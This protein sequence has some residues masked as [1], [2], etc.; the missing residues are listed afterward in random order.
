MGDGLAVFFDIGDTLA[1]PHITGGHL[2]GL[3]VYPFVPE[4]LAR[5][6][7]A[8]GNEFAVALGIVSN[9]GNETK[10]SLNDLLDKSGLSA[11]VDASL[12]LF[13]S[14]EGLDKSQPAFFVRAKD[15]AAVPSAQ[16]VFVERTRRNERL[17][18][19]SAFGCLRIHFMRCTS[20]RRRPLRTRFEQGSACPEDRSSDD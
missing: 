12:C 2:A 17:R 5:M 8:G 19:R 11:L 1:S 7:A 4:I 13:S 15:R 10:A 6:R 14:V 9:T 18:H 3:D 16:C 20:L